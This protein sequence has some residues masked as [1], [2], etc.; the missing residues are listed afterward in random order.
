M[1]GLSNPTGL[2]PVSVWNQFFYIE[3]FWGIERYVDDSNIN[4]RGH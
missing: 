4:T 2:V 1:L 3:D